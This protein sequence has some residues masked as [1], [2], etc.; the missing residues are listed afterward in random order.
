MNDFKT[1]TAGWY[2]SQPVDFEYNQYRLLA[3]IQMVKN[4]YLKSEVYPILNDVKFHFDDM[5]SV[6]DRSNTLN[7]NWKGQLRGI[8][9]ENRKLLYDS[10]FQLS[11]ELEEV[12]RT[13]EFSVPKLDSVIQEGKDIENFVIDNCL[14]E[15]VGLLPLYKKEGYLFLQNHK[16]AEIYIYRF[17]G[18]VLNSDNFGKAH[19]RLSF[20]HKTSR[21]I[22]ES[23]TSVKRNIIKKFKELPNPATFVMSTKMVFPIELTLIPLA[24]KL[25]AECIED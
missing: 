22:G 3:Y 8:D 5:Y 15:P 18:R 2:S 9:N 13:L 10:S 12:I 14:V 20:L 16:P 7:N 24:G 21:M 4:A 19:V 6:L 17:S 11:K 23:L 1:L 25:I